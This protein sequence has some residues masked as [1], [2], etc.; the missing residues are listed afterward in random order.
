MTLDD[1]REL[2]EKINSDASQV[3]DEELAAARD[4]I[5]EHVAEAKKAGPSPE[6]LKLLTDLKPIRESI[7]GE[8][9][10]RV[11]AKAEL[12]GET[13][14]LLAEYDEPVEAGRSAAD[15]GADAEVV[16]LPPRQAEQAEPVGIAASAELIASITKAAVEGATQA[17]TALQGKPAEQAT[18]QPQGRTG[19]VA[20]TVTPA[21]PRGEF[22][23]AQVFGGQDAAGTPIGSSLELAKALHDK[24]RTVYQDSAYSG[25]IPIAH[26][27]FEYPES[28]KLGTDAAQNFHKLEALTSRESL[29]AAGGL[30]APLTPDYNVEVIGTSARPIRDQALVGV[31]V[32][33]GGLLFRP[34]LSGAAAVNGAGQWTLDDDEAASVVNDSGPTKTCFE[35]DCPGMEEE[36]IWAAYLCLEF[37]NITT[38][39]DPET[40]AANLRQGD[41]AH[42]RLA[43]NLLLS[44]M[45][46]GSKALSGARVIG[47]T[48]DLLGNLD[49]AQA[50]LRSKHRIDEAMPLT[51][52][53]PFWVKHLVR[54]DLSRQMAAGDWKDALGV[55]DSELEGWFSRR[56]VSPVWHMDGIA[57][58][59]E[60]Q[61]VT[62][63]GSPTGGTFTLTYAGDT[64]DPIAYNAT[65][66][67]VKS[68]LAALDTLDAEDIT[69]TGGPGPG[70]AWT[71]TFGGSDSD[72]VN[73]AQMTSAG[74]FTGGSSP[75]V[76]VA[77]T[78]AG[79]GAITV[80]GI[81]IPSQTYDDAAAGSA[82]P[83]FPDK[84]DSL[85]YPT[86]TW[87]FLNGGSLDLGLVRDST[88]NA[89]NRY[90]QF[91]ETF[92]GAAHRGVES[93]R[94][95]MGVQPTGQTSGTKDLDA[96]V[97]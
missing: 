49:R 3:G 6:T 71:V 57:G 90:R 78:T 29:T 25:R 27:A 87:A 11:A 39:F 54:A 48:R 22:V 53:A 79:D 91:Q 77:T 24:Y 46:A 40:T 97:D 60:V 43:E 28:R 9:D 95:V 94:L 32:E 83:G 34:P 59:D 96:I 15:E 72:G 67:Q 51:W 19:R 4:A 75:A 93:L 68:A 1:L 2:A 52:V 33:R 13:Q 10:T 80:N 23:T 66:A 70:T 31:Q 14:R 55:A 84:I 30:C 45:M 36:F 44:K 7:V 92:E 16:E 88:L 35:V 74:S 20:T 50:Y 76:A 8:V 17:F 73:V 26:V 42:S 18:E 38:R 65:A 82:I 89:R 47:A 62:I 41:I 81:T 56:N 58:T 63:T 5:Q 61:T 64:T 12:D 85:L 21:A 69:V 37:S 86:G